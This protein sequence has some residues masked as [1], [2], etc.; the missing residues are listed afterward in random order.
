MTFRPGHAYVPGRSPRHPE[1]TFDAVRA[2]AADLEAS[3]AFRHGLL[4]L[5]EGFFWEAHEVLEP[6]WMALPEGSERSF[7]QGLIQLA[8]GRL[9]MRMD[10]P[11]AALRLARI[12]RGLVAARGSGL[13]MGLEVAEVLREVDDLED[14]ASGAL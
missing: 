2:D 11:G 12:A 5:R 4:Y 14:M 1:G 7:V 9:K 10:R 8:N 6:V 3:E 13:C